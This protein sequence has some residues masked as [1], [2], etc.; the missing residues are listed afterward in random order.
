M[1]RMVEPDRGQALVRIARLAAEKIAP[2][3]KIFGDAEC[4]FQR[5]AVAEIMRLFRQSQVRFAA[6]ELDRSSRWHQEARDQPQQR[7]LAG[8]VGAGD[9]ERFA[10]GRLKIEL[11]EHLAAASHTSDTAS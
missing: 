8:T 5:V 1:G 6:L 3:R 4:G 11:R 2:K 10:R 9:G 7:G